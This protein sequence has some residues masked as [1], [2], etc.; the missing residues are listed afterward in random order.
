MLWGSDW[1]H[2]PPHG[3]MAGEGGETVPYR[4]VRLGDLLDAFRVWFPDPAMQTRVL[5]TN[6]ARLYG[7]SPAPS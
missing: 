2:T 4:D 6:P 3:A 5:V 1:P 7:W